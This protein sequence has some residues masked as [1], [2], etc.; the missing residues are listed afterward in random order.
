MPSEV[1]CAADIR[2][3]VHGL[4]GHEAARRLQVEEAVVSDS[5]PRRVFERNNLVR[6]E[7]LLPQGLHSKQTEALD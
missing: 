7:R 2:L 1:N 3:T 6:D 5:E 4:Q